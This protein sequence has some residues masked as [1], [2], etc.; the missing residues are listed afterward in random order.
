LRRKKP[1]KRAT[2]TPLKFPRWYPD[3]RNQ[4]IAEWLAHNFYL[5]RLVGREPS[6]DVPPYN[7]FKRHVVEAFLQQLSNTTAIRS[8]V[9]TNV[10]A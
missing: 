9:P 3:D 10:S 5:D 2:P 8:L 1:P 4:G 6:P 7:E